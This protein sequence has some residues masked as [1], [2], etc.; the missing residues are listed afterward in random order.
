MAIPSS[1]PTQTL[2]A[3]C[4]DGDLDR[5]RNL[6]ADPAASSTALSE[7]DSAGP[8]KSRRIINLRNLVEKAARSAHAEN[9]ACLFAFAREHSV[10]VNAL[11]GRETLLAAASTASL[12]VISEFVEAQPSC[13]NTSLGYSGDLLA[14]AIVGPYVAM[15]DDT[16]PETRV[17]LV[18]YLLERGAD[19]NR[20]ACGF[21]KPGFHLYTAIARNKPTDMVRL[22]LE[23]G[24]QIKESGATVAA[25]ERGRVDVL[26]LL[27]EHGADMKEPRS[28]GIVHYHDKEMTAQRARE[29]PVEAARRENREAAVEWLMSHGGQ[30]E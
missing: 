29:T 22:L 6:L 9:V 24:A 15:A 30:S 23:H 14:Q 13:V 16:T 11:V 27:L 8:G 17:P 19:P 12:D 4:V 21:F 1:D 25:A 18:R 2:L 3:A 26:Q 28:E 10:D 7:V 20:H 5:L